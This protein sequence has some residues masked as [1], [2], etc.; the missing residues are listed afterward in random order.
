MSNREFERALANLM[1][2]PV[3]ALAREWKL[4]LRRTDEDDV[5][6]GGRRSRSSSNAGLGRTPADRRS[7]S[8]GGRERDQAREAAWGVK[9]NWAEAV[10]G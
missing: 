5:T 1:E 8:L 4:E 6:L 9:R 10:Q 2:Q 7:A 3:G